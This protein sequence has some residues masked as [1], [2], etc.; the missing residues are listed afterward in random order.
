[1]TA[2]A[3]PTPEAWLAVDPHHACNGCLHGTGERG[4]RQCCH[5]E[6]I[7]PAGQAVPSHCARGREGA[8]GPDAR[9][10]DMASWH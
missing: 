5:A 1:M 6:V 4:R 3:I 2:R 7:G 9:L 8:C 10:L